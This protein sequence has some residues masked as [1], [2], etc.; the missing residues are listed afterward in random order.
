MN[1]RVRALR[2]FADA[3]PAAE[4]PPPAPSDLESDDISDLARALSGM[5]VRSRGLLE[6]LRV[7]SARREA[8]LASMVEGVLAVDPHMRVMFCNDAFARALGARVPVP[9]GLPLLEVTRHPE[10]IEMLS[11]VQAHWPAGQAAVQSTTPQDRAFEVLVS[12]LATPGR[13]APSP[14]CTTLRN[15]NAWN[16]SA[17]ISSPT[18]RMNCVPR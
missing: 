4:P 5:A 11:S 17:K 3:F 7:E 6:T 16:G 8:I 1:R 13:R 14:F 18:C 10:I 9:D 15:S 2:D 12:P